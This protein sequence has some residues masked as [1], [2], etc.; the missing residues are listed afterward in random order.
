MKRWPLRVKVALLS[1]MVSMIAIALFGAAIVWNRYN[2]R[3]AELDSE[4]DRITAD[5]FNALAQRETPLQWSDKPEVRELFALVHHIYYVEV[6]QPVGHL[7]YRTANLPDTSLWEQPSEATRHT[8]KLGE[9]EV[10]ILGT[11]HGSTKLRI[12]ISMG[13]TERSLSDLLLFY[14]LSF[15]IVILVVGA[16]GFWL[17]RKALAPVQQIADAAERITAERLGESL[18]DVGAEDEIG[19]LTRVL[20][21]MFARLHTSF[22]QMSR[23]SADASHELKTPLTIIR[24]ELDA[25]LRGP[26]LPPALEESILD[27]LDE[28]GRLVTITEGLLLLSQADAG[29]LNISMVTLS[30]SAK[31]RDLTEDIEILAMPRSI[32][33]ETDYA[34]GVQVQANAHFLRQLLLNLFDNAIKYNHPQGQILTR[35]E[36]CGTQAIFTISNTGAGIPAAESELVFQRFHRA[37]Q[38]RDRSTGGQGLGLSLCREIARAHGGD[39]RLVPAEHG[40]T[41]FEVALPCADCDSSGVR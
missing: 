25:I 29:K 41:T 16:G 18:P 30:L 6:E 19:R 31:L 2:V 40:W 7:V 20:N 10:R 39:I 8:V 22:E 9:K 12:G 13:R 26:K 15:P 4:L 38:S 33:V 34:T 32:K 1:A 5:F 24:G 23:F 3:V 37:D 27:V 21:Q 36:R 35:L 14:V 11:V 28:T 17:A